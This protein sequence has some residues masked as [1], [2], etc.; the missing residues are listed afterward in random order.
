MFARLVAGA[1]AL[2][3]TAVAPAAEI[4][5]LN[6]P[7]GVYNTGIAGSTYTF[8]FSPGSPA[9]SQT[10]G[11]TYPTS[12]TAVTATPGQFPLNHYTNGNA[13][14]SQWIL[15]RSNAGVSGD[16]SDMNGRFVFTTT[17]TAPAGTSGG[18]ILGRVA[19]DNQVQAILLNGVD[20]GF[21]GGPMS[22][23]SNGFP[24]TP[25]SVTGGFQPGLNTLSF[26]VW[27]QPQTGGNPVG[28]NVNLQSAVVHTP[29]P[30]TLAVVGLTFGAAGFRA[31]RRKRAG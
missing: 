30:A 12:G 22:S 28:L 18:E 15:T 26:V 20:S 6:T 9:V 14:G 2:A 24:F 23:P 7:G 17:F 8:Q 5:I 11:N 27:N 3:W 4:S 16:F 10:A 31:W 21:A 25:F 29:E 19:A 1:V 13:A